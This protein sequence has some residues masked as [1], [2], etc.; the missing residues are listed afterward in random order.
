MRLA[1]FA[2]FDK[3]NIIK[4]YVIYYLEQLKTVCHKIIFVSTSELDSKECFK[5]RKLCD[6]V[7]TRENVG[8]DFYSYK[9]GIQSIENIA[10]IDQLILCNDS[11]FGPLFSFA[12]LFEENRFKYYDVWGMSFNHRPKL[13][14]QSFFLVFNNYAITH[15]VF[16]EFWSNVVIVTDK[17]KIVNDYEVGL[18][19]KMI[20]NDFQLGSMLPDSDYSINYCKLFWRKLVI[21]L[22]EQFNHDSRYCW[23][24]IFEPLRRIDKTIS[25]FDYSIKMYKFPFLKK[26][27]LSDK[28][29]S[30]DEIYDIIKSHTG[31]DINLIKDVVNA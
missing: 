29:I 30:K 5:L 12:E 8:H 9:V 1:I 16:Q 18:S 31:Y 11:C 6:K 14:L 2:H 27:L 28:W 17:D 21:Q 26:S 7:I 3:S 10:T 24:N 15:S 13:H 20:I 19:Q 23:K 4:P 25:L 22:G